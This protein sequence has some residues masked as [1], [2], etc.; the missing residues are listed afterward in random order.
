[1]QS[2]RVGDL[3]ITLDK[4][5]LREY[6]KV[7][8]PVRYG[9]FSEFCSPKWAC[10]FNLNGELKFIQGRGKDWP[11][12]AEWLK[13]TAGNDWIYYSSGEYGEIFDL[14]GEYYLPCLSYPSN[15]IFSMSLL[16]HEA[17]QSAIRAW[18][19]LCETLNSIS[20]STAP[21]PLRDFLQ[22]VC[23]HDPDTLQ[24]KAERLHALIGGQV[25]VLPPDTR[26]VDYDVLPLV[27]ADGCLYNCGFCAVKSD[28]A[29]R[30]RT[31]QNIVEQVEGLRSIYARDLPNYNAVFLGQH[32]ALQAGAELLEFAAAKAYDGLE[33]ARSHMK[34]PRLFLFGSTDSLLQSS[35]G[36]F[37]TLSRLPFHTY[38]NVGLE[39]ADPS[40]LTA[41]EKPITAWMVEHAFERMLEINRRYPRIEISAN[42]IFGGQLP[43]THLSSLRSLVRAKL[44]RF[45]EKGAVYLSPLIYAVPLRGDGKRKLVRQFRKVKIES[46]LP[47]YLYLIQRL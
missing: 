16:D 39:S 37:E 11:H 40:T 9:C 4:W 6:T 42:F 14:F 44:N 27:V 33:M 24:R 7:S 22:R 34:G 23:E 31:E 8:Y 10:Q 20:S 36:L 26:H 12:P 41:L 47:M 46:R 18:G 45:S 17:E 21:G 25:T 3:E 35:E 38:I 28:H 2:Y 1:M 13:R 29:F 32:D 5:G 43:P 19:S 30:P 15:S